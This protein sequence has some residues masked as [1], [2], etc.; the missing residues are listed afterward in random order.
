MNDGR[1]LFGAIAVFELAHAAMAGALHRVPTG[2]DGFQYF[3]LQYYFLN[4]AIQAR[5][6]AQWIPYM[7]QG[8][9]ATFWYAVQSSLLQNVLLW[10]APLL[11]HVDLLPVFYAG[12][13]V[14]ELIL[15]TGTDRRILEFVA[16]PVEVTGRL[17]RSGGMLTL[18]TQPAAIRRRE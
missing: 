16:E 10:V 2:H 18:E 15:L 8:T 9:V 3:T 6:I 14:D 11:R 17:R 5:E 13:F 1:R 12:M 4:N 7:T